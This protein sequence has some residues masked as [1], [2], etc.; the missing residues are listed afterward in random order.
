MFSLKKTHSF[1][2]IISSRKFKGKRNV[3]GGVK[4]QNPTSQ[5][6][7]VLYCVNTVILSEE[8]RLHFPASIIIL[9]FYSLMKVLS[10]I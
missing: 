4:A 7:S 10:S 8:S 6:W 3:G 9:N 2:V 5:R 1:S